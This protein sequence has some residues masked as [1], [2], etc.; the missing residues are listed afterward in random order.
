MRCALCHA[1]PLCDPAVVNPS[2]YCPGLK[3]SPC[4]DDDPRLVTKSV[5]YVSVR[6]ALFF[7]FRKY[8]LGFGKTGETRFEK[9]DGLIF[10]PVKFIRGSM[11]I[12]GYAIP[13]CLVHVV[14]FYAVA[15]QTVSAL[16]SSPPSTHQSAVV[17][18]RAGRGRATWR[19]WESPEVIRPWA[20]WTVRLPGSPQSCDSQLR[21]HNL[22]AHAM[23]CQ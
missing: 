8:L 22:A 14:R 11:L 10:T 18:G 3:P 20:G 17:T 6:C 16:P 9:S 5:S 1:R 15:S 2:A 7:H 21:S 23:S 19:V 13:L 12:Q 4:R